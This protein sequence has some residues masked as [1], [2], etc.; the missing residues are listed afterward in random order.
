MA[1]LP[2]DVRDRSAGVGLIPTPIQLLGHHPELDNEIAGQVL[3][4]DLAAL[5][6]PEPDDRLLIIA[7]DNPGVRAAD[8]VPTVAYL[9]R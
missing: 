1:N 9:G 2:L 5:F 3:R 6:A 7:H 8:K 4:F